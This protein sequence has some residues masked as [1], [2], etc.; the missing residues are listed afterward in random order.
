MERALNAFRNGDAGINEI[1]RTYGVPKPTLKRRLKNKSIKACKGIKSFGRG[2]DLPT[3]LEEELVNH[4]LLL[5]SH[6]FGCSRY[7]LQKLA[8]DLAEANGIKHGKAGKQWYYSFM[9]RHPTLSLHQP[10]ATSAARAFGFNREAVMKFFDILADIIKSNKFQA[11]DIFNMDETSLSTVQKPQKILAQNGKHHVGAITS[12]ERGTNTTCVCCISASGVYVPPM[13]VLR[14][15]GS[16]TTLSP[17]LHLGH[18]LLCQ[19]MGG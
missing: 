4:V 18:S 12:G 14:E 15:R 8:Y 10:E 3:E 17:V 9:S 2:T 7:E 16:P 19:T 1:C 11:M 5:E 13:L 6:M